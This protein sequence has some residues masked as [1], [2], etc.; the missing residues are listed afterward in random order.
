MSRSFSLPDI[1]ELVECYSDD[2]LKICTYY[3]GKRSL[4]E[5]AYQDVFLK[6]LRKSDTFDGKCP[7]KYWLLSI[8]RNVCKDYLK[9]AWSTK[10]SSF[11]YLKEAEGEKA[12]VSELH[13]SRI[14][15]SVDG[16][17]QED[18]YFDRQPPEGD[19]WDAI[20]ALPD[21]YKDVVLY[22]YYFDMDNAAIAKVCKI[23]ESSV[24]SRLFRVRKKLIKFE[25]RNGR[26]PGELH[27]KSI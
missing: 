24:R 17:Q 11:D 25:K 2:V 22:K 21:A 6:V 13:P 5:D 16:R 18:L 27:E 10:I 14:T 26:L 12:S 19:L 9:S 4:A 3:L 20:N 15:P 1:E 7:P 8:A 23:T